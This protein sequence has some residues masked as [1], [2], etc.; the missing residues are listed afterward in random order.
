M[1]AVASF[2]CEGP[3]AYVWAT[4]GVGPHAVGVT[5]VLHYDAT[6]QRWRPANRG[7]VCVAHHLPWWIYLEGCFSN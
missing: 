1:S 5:E 2:G 4:L 7:E 3:W 6:T